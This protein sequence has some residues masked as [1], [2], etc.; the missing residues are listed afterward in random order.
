MDGWID[1]CLDR[2]MTKQVTASLCALREVTFLGNSFHYL[3]GG[4][5]VVLML[6]N[7]PIAH[8]KLYGRVS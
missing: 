4:I 2:W 7:F 8:I 6:C 3:W 5:Q 1:R